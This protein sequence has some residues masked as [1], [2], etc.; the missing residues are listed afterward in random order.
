MY[1]KN[2][3]F[4]LRNTETVSFTISEMDSAETWSALVSF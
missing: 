3:F 1:F 4:L 2:K